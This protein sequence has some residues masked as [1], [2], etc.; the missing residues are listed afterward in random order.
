M[1]LRYQIIFSG[2]D[3]AFQQFVINYGPRTGFGDDWLRLG[4]IKLFVDG[5]DI[6]VLNDGD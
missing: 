1:R 4:G 2:T 5:G 3:S 6:R